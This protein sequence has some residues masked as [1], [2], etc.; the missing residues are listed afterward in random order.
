MVRAGASFM[1]IG[2]IVVARQRRPEIGPLGTGWRCG[3]REA[4]TRGWG[5]G[6]DGGDGGNRG[7]RG[8]G[9]APRNIGDCRDFP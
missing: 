4:E 5:N 2:P 1:K 6:G 3:R 7:N 9:G 8:V